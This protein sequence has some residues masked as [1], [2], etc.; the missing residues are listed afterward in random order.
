MK[1]KLF[2]LLPMLFAGC[3]ADPVDN[4]QTDRKDDPNGG[5]YWELPPRILDGAIF[6]RGAQTWMAPQKDPY[7]LTN[8]KEAYNRLASGKSAQ[9]LTRAWTDEF[10]GAP[11]LK[12]THYALRIFPKS[13]EEQWKIELMEGI[14]VAY[15]PFD[16]VQL[17]EEEIKRLPTAKTRSGYG[18]TEAAESAIFSESY[19]YTVTYTDLETLEGAVVDETYILP[20]LYAV[21]PV[22]KSF[23]DDI[24]YEI[25]YEVFLPRYGDFQT[26]VSGLSEEALRVLEN[27]AISLALGIPVPERVAETRADGMVVFSGILADY[28]SRLNKKVPMGNLKMKWQLGSLMIADATNPDGSFYLGVGL[29]CNNPLSLFVYFQDA[30]KSGRWKITTEN[31][32]APYSPSWYIYYGVPTA[33]HDIT[34]DV[35]S[36]SK[37]GRRANEIHRAVNYFYNTQTDFIK[38][39]YVGGIRIIAH[40]NPPNGLYGSFLANYSNPANCQITVYNAVLP[41]SHLIGTTLHELGHYQHFCNSPSNLRK[42]PRFLTESFATYVGWYFGEK[43]HRTIGWKPS[44]VMDNITGES[45]QNW[46]IS[47][48]GELPE[49]TPLFVDLTDDNNQVDIYRGVPRDEIKNV[50]ARIVWSIIAGSTNWAQCKQKIREQVGSAYCTTAQLN[51]YL[52]DY[53]W[54]PLV[55]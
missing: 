3:S 27:E 54:H 16:H 25:D 35:I 53:E 34:G 43:Y 52:A 11:E 14:N 38:R 17:S 1:K 10:S 37:G 33:G 36:I 48:F 20:I 55:H 5:I 42:T 28:D 18:D 13:E 15:I 31:S 44:N 50:P 24:E 30:S 6:H 40:K 9:I 39:Y 47:G 4:F 29:P 21:W 26:R 12:P 49:Y 51:N 7:T 23:P 45:R 19:R 32:T 2:Y 46:L 22:D 8:F 41:D